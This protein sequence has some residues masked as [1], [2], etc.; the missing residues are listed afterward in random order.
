[1]KKQAHIV[2]SGRVQGVGFRFNAE[3]IAEKLGVKGWVKNL[4]DGRV[5]I[6]A[7]AEEEVL[8]KFL[9]GINEYFSQYIRGVDIEYKD[10]IE[11]IKEFR[12]EF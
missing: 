11:G 4:K 1:M 3:Y 2:Y 10:K 6:V 5:E 8:K 7:E 12:V 9:E